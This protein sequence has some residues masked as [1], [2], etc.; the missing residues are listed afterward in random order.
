MKKTILILLMVISTSCAIAQ[1]TIT[2]ATQSPQVGQSVN[3]HFD[4]DVS[5]AAIYLTGAN[6]T[7]D[8]SNISGTLTP[9][10]FIDISNSTSPNQF[11]DANIVSEDSGNEIYLKN[12]TTSFS[13]VGLIIPNAATIHYSDPREL[14]TFPMTYNDVSNESFAGSVT[15]ATGQTLT[16][17]GNSLIMADGYGDLVLPY[18]T[19]SNVLRVMDVANYT[20]EING[21]VLFNYTDTIVTW[22]DQNTNLRVAT[23]T[24]FYVNGTEFVAPTCSYLSEADLLG[25]KYSNLDH[26]PYRLFPN[27]TENSITID[28]PTND[29][30]TIEIYNNLGAYVKSIENL[31]GTQHLELNDL[32]TGMYIFKISNERN[33]YIE[34]VN[35]R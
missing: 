21:T 16:R 20:D 24:I 22:Y 35:I 4:D 17:S 5:K 30:I 1:I 6:Q 29:K 19:V 14:V 32:V 13:Q 15:N 23:M 34:K 2:S 31:H 33:A 27:P 7:W 25:L 3:Y 18:G 9:T 10:E 12:S 26:S 28:N 8:I 11:T